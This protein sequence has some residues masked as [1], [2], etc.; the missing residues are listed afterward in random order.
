MCLII[1][2][3]K[4]ILLR[5][6]ISLFPIKV[7]KILIDGH[8]TPYRFHQVNFINGKCVLS[9]KFN[10]NF[11]YTYTIEEGIHGYYKLKNATTDLA[12][13]VGEGGCIYKAIIP[14]F[15][16]YFY[17]WNG[18]IVSEKMIIKDVPHNR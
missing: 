18:N 10:S 11:R 4:H 6:K 5:P 14:P 17:G 3:K 2:L 12:H 15:T 7:F 16:K 1:N 9:A 13:F 8:L